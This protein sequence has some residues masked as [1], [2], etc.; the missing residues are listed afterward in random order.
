MMEHELKLLVICQSRTSQHIDTSSMVVGDVETNAVVS[1]AVPVINEV[2]KTM[3]FD[4][5]KNT[6]WTSTRFGLETN[7]VDSKDG[8]EKGCNKDKRRVL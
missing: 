2:D 6:S 7:I 5:N 1:K 8:D 4:G 3:T